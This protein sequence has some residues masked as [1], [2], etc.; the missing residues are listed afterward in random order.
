MNIISTITNH[1]YQKIASNMFE[2]GNEYI[3][4]KVNTKNVYIQPKKCSTMKPNTIF[5]KLVEISEKN[6]T[7][8]FMQYR[9]TFLDTL[10]IDFLKT[11]SKR[12]CVLKKDLHEFVFDT[13]YKIPENK[14]VMHIFCNIL[15][16][17]IIVVYHNNFE[18]YKNKN[19]V[20]ETIVLYNNYYREY[21][22]VNM[23]KYRLIEEQK[24]EIVNFD[25]LKVNELKEYAQ[26]HNIDISEYK[27]KKDIV[28]VLKKIVNKN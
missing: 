20:D 6:N 8:D 25:N 26:I 23:A 14:N 16:K 28:A 13:S 27:K 3:I 10:S 15:N 4:N 18:L 12:V 5:E 21:N 11:I 17:N 19:T 7:I 24:Y 22:N 2:Q 9:K 1:D